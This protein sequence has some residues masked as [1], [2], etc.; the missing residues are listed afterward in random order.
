M[1]YRVATPEDLPQVSKVIEDGGAYGPIDASTL[2][3][4]IIVADWEGEIVGCMW[5][6]VCGRHAYLDCFNVKPKFKGSR[7]AL[8]LYLAMQK[9][10]EALGVK[11]V[12]G[13]IKADN[14]NPKRLAEFMGATGDDGYM[15]YYKE[16]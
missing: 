12:R 15:L 1:K 11:Y 3:G 13:M 10:L 16:I 4:V 7:A 2:D 8:G 6:M 14:K 9:A 5:A